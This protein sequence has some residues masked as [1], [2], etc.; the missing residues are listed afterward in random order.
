V[1]RRTTDPGAA[2]RWPRAWPLV[3]LAA[4]LAGCRCPDLVES[5]DTPQAALD[6]WQ[7]RLCRDDVEG[8]YACL[9][10]SFQLAING[11]ET[12][13]PLRTDLLQRDPAAAWLFR[14]ADLEEHVV[15]QSFDP[16]GRRAVLVLQAGD[17]QLA[18]SFEREAFVTVVW[19]D[20]RSETARQRARPDELL[21]RD[22][23]SRRQWLAIERPDI[24]EPQRV[25]EVRFASRW[26]IADIAGLAQPA[27]PDQEIVP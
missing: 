25:R 21:V 8:E 3:L 4:A 27:D 26:L 6:T 23:R 13:Y 7:A 5:W 24:T 19:D 22:E 16:D 14:R 20:G 18:V 12:Y 11:F 17:T 9:A 1:T 10:R 15:S 2:P